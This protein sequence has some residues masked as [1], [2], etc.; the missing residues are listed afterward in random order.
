MKS[1][2]LTTFGKTKVYSAGISSPQ[3]ERVL[4]VPGFSE[5]I[6]HNKGLVDALA[7]Q[8]FD[9]STFSQ[10]R[11]RSKGGNSDVI[12]RQ[13]DLLLEVVKDTVPQGE[14]VHAV[15]HSLGSAA[16]LRAAQQDPER[17]ISITLMQPV[18]MADEQSLPEQITRAGT[19]VI[20]NQ[21]GTFNGQDPNRQPQNGYAASVDTESAIHFSGRVSWAQ[22][23]SSG[24][25]S[26]QLSL[27]I[28]EAKAAD[29]YDISDD[30][31]RVKELG[32][33]VNIVTSQADEMFDPD[34]V[35]AGYEALGTMPSS[36]SSVADKD[37]RHD[38]FWMQPERTAR[39]VEQL[40][41]QS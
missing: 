38:T 5:S 6:S 19:K 28:R 36:Y 29:E 17:F 32:I 20:K 8:G 23:V 3:A 2:V 40:I 35:N 1:T 26:R 30:L 37:A 25:L 31:A 41:N 13:A 24:V 9:A 34:K 16:I 14:K 39:I 10:P 7:T 12:Q 21:T 18:G 33:P 27:A 15:A 22:L 11:H 4:A